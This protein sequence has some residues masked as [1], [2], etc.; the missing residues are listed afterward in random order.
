MV[1]AVGLLWS[2]TAT[3]SV[4]GDDGS[5][6]SG[7]DGSEVLVVPR[8]SVDRGEKKEAVKQKK[9]PRSQPHKCYRALSLSDLSTSIALPSGKLP[10]DAAAKCAAETPPTSDLRLA[11]AWAVTEQHW[12][13]T[14]LCHRPLYFEEINAERYGYTP[15][16]FLQPL[17]SA[18]H[19]FATIPALPYKMAIDHPQDCSYTL[20]HYRPGSC[21]PWRGNRLPL[22]LKGVAVEAAF[23][24]ALILLLP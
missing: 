1:L 4:S 2:T 7:D 23:I 13:A 18:G 12:S 10:T 19:F 15:S 11:G 5:S 8:P 14:C 24:A 21:A 9:K 20:G 16:Y 3:V 22:R 6:V 17:I